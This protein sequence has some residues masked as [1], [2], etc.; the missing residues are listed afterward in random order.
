M[1]SSFGIGLVI[2]GIVLG[3]IGLVISLNA[4]LIPP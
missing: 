3:L 2:G 4:N 1:E